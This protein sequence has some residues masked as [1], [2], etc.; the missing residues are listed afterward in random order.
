MLMDGTRAAGSEGRSASLAPTTVSRT[1]PNSIPTPKQAQPRAG[2]PTAAAVS[3][4]TRP[5]ATEGIRYPPCTA[6]ART[7]PVSHQPT[8]QPTKTASTAIAA[9]TTIVPGSGAAAWSSAPSS[10]AVTG[11]SAASGPWTGSV[12]WPAIGR[13]LRCPRTPCQSASTS[14]AP[15]ARTQSSGAAPAGRSRLFVAAP[16]TSASPARPKAMAQVPSGSRVFSSMT[17]RLAGQD[18]RGVP[19]PS[20]LH[21]PLPGS[22]CLTPTRFRPRASDGV[23]VAQHGEDPPMVVV[24][25][26]EI[27][28]DHDA[29]HVLLH[30]R[31]GDP[32]RAC[33]PGVRAALRHLHENLVLAL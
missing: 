15:A 8:S 5:P 31:L 12:S 24:V 20:H 14:Q 26:V 19:A 33:D 11:T 21:Y 10:M 32:Q 29:A 1:A 30:R 28:L 3:A 4:A 27:E 6:S 23:E 16:H 7:C 2:S 13:P 17:P 9:T 18:R 22:G 25:G